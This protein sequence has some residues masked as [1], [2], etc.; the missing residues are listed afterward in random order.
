MDKQAEEYEIFLEIYGAEINV[1]VLYILEKIG[2]HGQDRNRIVFHYLHLHKDRSLC[3]FFVRMKKIEGIPSAIPFFIIFSP[4]I[5]T[6]SSLS[7]H[8]LGCLPCPLV[9]ITWDGSRKMTNIKEK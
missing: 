2:E 7:S 1:K 8:F 4:P 3:C 5:Q 9:L 6:V